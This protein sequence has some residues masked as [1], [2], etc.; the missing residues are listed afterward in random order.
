MTSSPKGRKGHK[1]GSLLYQ[2]TRY[3]WCAGVSLISVTPSKHQPYHSDEDPT[4]LP[5]FVFELPPGVTPE[6][7]HIEREVE[8]ELRRRLLV[9]I[10]STT[11]K[12]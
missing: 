2:K 10:L 5:P 3:D 7:L 8:G 6:P 12:S 11:D 4:P 9:T 1:T